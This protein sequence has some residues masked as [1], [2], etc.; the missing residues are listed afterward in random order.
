MT[1][2]APLAASALWGSLRAYDAEPLLAWGRRVGDD[3]RKAISHLAPLLPDLSIGSINGH[4]SVTR[5]FGA[6]APGHPFNEFDSDWLTLHEPQ[7]TKAFASFL[8]EGDASCV[9]AFLR[10]LDPD[11]NWPNDMSELLVEAEMPTRKGFIDI[12]IRYRSG[13]ELFGAVVEA[14]FGH[15]AK[16][17]P[18]SDYHAVARSDVFQGD[19]SNVSYRI[20]GQMQCTRTSRLVAGKN[21][22][23]FVSWFAFLRRLEAALIEAPS[24]ERFKRFRRI[25]WEKI[26]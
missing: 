1:S 5:F 23:Q 16:S 15:D 14:K 17:N 6:D 3:A 21:P 13:A 19:D 12:L 2:T 20:L 10:A 9:L 22:W 8:A 24:S 26:L 7:V 4:L 18:F 11:R 25:V